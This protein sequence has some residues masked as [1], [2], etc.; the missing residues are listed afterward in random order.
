MELEGRKRD[1][2]SAAAPV[3]TITVTICL[4]HLLNLNSTAVPHARGTMATPGR[5][6]MIRMAWNGTWSG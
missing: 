4:P 2:K 5:A 6:S 1:K 3:K